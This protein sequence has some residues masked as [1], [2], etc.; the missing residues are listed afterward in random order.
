MN[1]IDVPAVVAVHLAAFRGYMTAALG[2][3]YA[4]SFFKWFVQAPDAIAITGLIGNSPVGYVV[5]APFGYQKRLNRKIAFAAGVGILCR[6]WLILRSD[7]RRAIKSRIDA[8]FSCQVKD[9]KMD[10]QR[11]RKALSGISLVG[12]GV[13]P[14]GRGQG[15]G[16]K[17]VSAFESEARDRGIAMLR[18][19]VYRENH[20]ACRL[21][22]RMGWRCL[23]S[24]TG[25]T[26]NYVKTWQDFNDLGTE[27][28]PTL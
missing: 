2:K 28:Q 8:T 23:D 11:I 21:Y 20:A 5:G 12:I 4:F 1:V 26:V 22:E 17:L 25:Q 6:P 14:I 27:P 7:I 15:L 18:L 13:A 19:S 10:D 9:S 16:A 3:K 24:G